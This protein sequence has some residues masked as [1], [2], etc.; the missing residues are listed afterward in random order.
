MREGE[1]R[2]GCL[3]LGPGLAR[4][5]PCPA[6]R[7]HVLPLAR[8][9]RL[10]HIH[11]RTRPGQVEEAPGAIPS[12]W[13]SCIH[14]WR[15]G[16]WR[17][18]RPPSQPPPWRKRRG[19]PGGARACTRL[20][21]GRRPLH[22]SGAAQD[23]LR[24]RPARRRVERHLGQGGDRRPPLLRS[25]FRRRP[26]SRESRCRPE[27]AARRPARRATVDR[28]SPALGCSSSRSN[29][30]PEE[31]GEMSTHRL[32]CLWPALAPAPRRLLSPPVGAGAASAPP[33]RAY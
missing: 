29:C 9:A 2:T 18:G 19:A 22:S 12:A 32:L 26:R 10:H 3:G 25:C 13:Q 16:E 4:D 24:S 20:G 30:L 33:P 23:G 7:N 1:L 5:P 14:P 11:R 17:A 15:C 27:A 8:P 6:G 21:G 31:G 28:Q